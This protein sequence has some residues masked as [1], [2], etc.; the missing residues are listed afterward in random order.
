MQLQ[1]LTGCRHWD[2]S[3]TAQVTELRVKPGPSG[4]S[5]LPLAYWTVVK[6]TFISHKQQITICF[7][8]TVPL[9]STTEATSCCLKG[10]SHLKQPRTSHLLCGSRA[11]KK[12]PLHQ[13]SP[14]LP[15]GLTFQRCVPAFAI[16]HCF[17][18][19]APDS[20]FSLNK[21]LSNSN[22]NHDFLPRKKLWKWWKANQGYCTVYFT[23]V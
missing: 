18:S 13:S 7:N 16:V 14:T 1:A 11:E 21:A 8:V 23:L 19:S 17:P 5:P 12:G 15:Q 6:H 10:R 9:F 3:G 22:R 4:K 2:S 20:S